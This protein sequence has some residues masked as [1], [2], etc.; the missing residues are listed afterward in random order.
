M[1]LFRRLTNNT[2]RLQPEWSR[3][4]PEHKK[5]DDYQ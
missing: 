1:R 2:G 5:P 4:V 3:N